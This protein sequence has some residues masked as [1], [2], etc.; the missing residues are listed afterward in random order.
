MT[1]LTFSDAAKRAAVSRQTIYKYVSQGRLSATLAHD[2]RRQIEV[3]ELL[4]VFG[5]LHSPDDASSDKADARRMSATTPA[6]E[7]ILELERAKMQIQARD[8][9]LALLRERVEELKAREQLAKD[10]AREAQEQ[11]SRLLGI[12]EM[13]GRLLAAPMT[14]AKAEAAPSKKKAAKGAKK[15]G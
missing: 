4:R 2:G 1:Q 9:E 5:H 15:A 6:T 12:V 13:Q 11:Q 10:Q 14:P 8:T 7:V 3:T